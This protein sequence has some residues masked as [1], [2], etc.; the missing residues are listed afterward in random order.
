[1]A[2]ALGSGRVAD[3]GEAALHDL[4]ALRRAGEEDAQ[5]HRARHED[6]VLL[7]GGG[8]EGDRLLADELGAVGLEPGV[9]GAR[10][11]LA[12]NRLPRTVVSSVS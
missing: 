2:M 6:A 11:A 8:G 12:R 4:P 1:M 9:E 3:A 5:A 7:G 10:G